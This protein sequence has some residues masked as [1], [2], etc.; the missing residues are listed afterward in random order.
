MRLV[1]LHLA[2]G[3]QPILCMRG[4]M[5]RDEPPHGRKIRAALSRHICR[6]SGRDS[7]LQAWRVREGYQRKACGEQPQRYKARGK[8]APAVA[9]QAGALTAHGSVAGGNAVGY[10]SLFNVV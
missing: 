5:E 6:E 8:G 3:S 1:H 10:W 9:G 7:L 2:S 4:E